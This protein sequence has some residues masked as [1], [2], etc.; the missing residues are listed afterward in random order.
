MRMFEVYVRFANVIYFRI[1]WRPQDTGRSSFEEIS[2]NIEKISLVILVHRSRCETSTIVSSTSRREMS[3]N[4]PTRGL[5]A[6]H[7]Y[8]RR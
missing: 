6:E 8:S 3:K 4:I 1:V 7:G 5:P 2:K